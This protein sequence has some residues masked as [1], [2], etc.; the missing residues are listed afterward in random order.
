M[1]LTVVDV[2]VTRQ[3]PEDVVVAVRLR[4]GA[5]SLG[6]TVVAVSNL[7]LAAPRL[8]ERLVGGRDGR[9]RHKRVVRVRAGIGD[10]PRVL[11]KRVL[12][13]HERH[14]KSPSG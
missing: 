14:V 1:S 10:V 6:S 5:R 7:C 11:R 9:R 3:G 13:S 4:I 8:R 12:K 2:V